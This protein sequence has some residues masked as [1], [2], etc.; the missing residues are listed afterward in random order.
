M[1]K[2]QQKCKAF[3]DKMM[4]VAVQSKAWVRSHLIA[5]TMGSNPAKSTYV[6][7]SCLLCVVFVKA[8]AMS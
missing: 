6:R 8:S 5:G 1:T 7:L 4:P 3:Y 2:P